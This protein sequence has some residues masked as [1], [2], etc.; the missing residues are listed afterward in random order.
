MKCL[1]FLQLLISI[2]KKDFTYLFQ[3]QREKERVRRDIGGGRKNLKQT[4]HWAWSPV[5]AQSHNHK[6]MTWAE[7]KSWMLNQ[8]SHPGA[9]PITDFSS[10]HLNSQFPL[11]NIFGGFHNFLLSFTD[12]NFSPFWFKKSI[13]D[14]I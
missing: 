9:P 6:I 12:K 2:F 11:S 8:P 4:L 1:Y 7:T 14:S 5:G 10:V 13:S 3:R